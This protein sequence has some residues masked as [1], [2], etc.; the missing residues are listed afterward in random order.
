MI[1]LMHYGGYGMMGWFGM[2]IPLILIIVI[3]YVVTKLVKD[4]NGSNN[5]RNESDTALNI[6]NERYSKG[7]ISEEEYKQMKKNLRE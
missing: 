5:M 7:E 3:A 1:K 2:I 6:L 4:N